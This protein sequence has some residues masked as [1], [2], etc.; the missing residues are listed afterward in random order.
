M[1]TLHTFHFCFLFVAPSLRPCLHDGRNVFLFSSLLCPQ[2]LEPC[3]AHSK[4]SINTEPA[5]QEEKNTFVAARRTCGRAGAI[6]DC[7]LGTKI[8]E[9]LGAR[10]GK[11]RRKIIPRAGLSQTVQALL[12][13]P[14]PT[15]PL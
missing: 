5:R 4:R 11:I 6:V 13:S 12:Q 9:L 10:L 15:T 8:Q 14:V 1:L 7:A 2:H 3:L